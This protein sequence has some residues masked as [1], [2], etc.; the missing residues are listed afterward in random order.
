MS[1]KLTENEI[2]LA[3]IQALKDG[4]KSKFQ[5]IIDELLPYDLAYQFKQIS[6]K[7]KNKFITYL[8][9]EQLTQFDSGT[10]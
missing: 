4:S 3:L 10:G 1:Q 5:L 2:L 7:H 8:T 9:I 6:P